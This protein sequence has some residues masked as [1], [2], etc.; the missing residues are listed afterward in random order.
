MPRDVRDRG[1][2]AHLARLGRACEAR[3]ATRP[4]GK[5]VFDG[6]AS[7]ALAVAWTP[8][9]DRATRAW[10]SWGPGVHRVRDGLRRRGGRVRRR[11]GKRAVAHAPG[12]DAR[13]PRR[14]ARRTHR[15]ARRGRRRACTPSAPRPAGGAGCA[16][17]APSAGRRTSRRTKARS[18]RSTAG[19]RR[20]LVAGDAR[21]CSTRSRSKQALAC[22]DRATGRVRWTAGKQRGLVPVAG[23]GHARAGSEQVVRG[24][25][26]AS[27]ASIPRPARC[28]GSTTPR[29]DGSPI[30][31]GSR[32]PSSIEG[33]RMLVTP[34]Q[35]DS[36]VLFR[37]RRTGM[38]GATATLW[39]TKGFRTTYARPVYHKRAS[40]RVRGAFLA[41]VDA[42]TGERPVASRAPGDG[43]LG[44]RGRAPGRADEDRQPARGRSQPR[45]LQGAGAAPGV[46]RR[47]F[48]DGAE[49]RRRALL[50]PRHVEGRGGE[51]VDAGPGRTGGARVDL[52]QGPRSA[53][54]LEEVGRA[55][56]KTAAVDAFLASVD[57]FPLIEGDVVEFLY[58]G[59]GKRP[60]NRQRPHRRA[61]PAA[62]APG[63]GHRPLLLDGARSP[64]ARL[65][66]PFRARPGRERSPTRATRGKEP[67]APGRHVL[68]RDAG[69]GGAGVPGAGP[70]RRARGGWN[71][72]D[73]QREDP[74]Q[75]EARRLP[76]AGYDTSTDRL[77]VVYVPG[78]KDAIEQGG[79]PNTLDHLI[80]AQRAPMVVVFVHPQ[81]PRRRARAPGRQGQ[82]LSDSLAEE[83]VPFVDRTYRT[84]AGARGRV[85]SSAGGFAGYEALD[86]AFRRPESSAACPPS[87]RSC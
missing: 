85:R 74:G 26:E 57:S 10:R 16:R 68:V 37:S 39:T 45:G 47:P 64:E 86:A 32:C 11:S 66:V 44:A 1:A 50:R 36:A 67:G 53:R 82:K 34:R 80:G 63:R 81:P 9:P 2:H 35:D 78:G 48:L 87:R 52:P 60:G 25:E 46:P 49:R 8:A 28:C 41:C 58:R 12:P 61:G 84:R 51:V 38:R 13:G 5:G 21:S 43:F 17:A 55:A 22:F 73:R 20:P 23:P 70:R 6:V 27:T 71:A 31:T 79:L 65:L 7:P 4:P 56:D 18:R 24:P 54:F 19:P 59:P 75:A 3:A 30:A 83:V 77:P 15:H 69:L 14:I 33:D 72:R 42:A 76:A 40:L 29:R 62:D